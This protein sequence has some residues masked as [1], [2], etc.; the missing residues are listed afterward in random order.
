MKNR[1][2][3]YIMALPIAFIWF[4]CN[5]YLD[6]MPDN[7]MELDSESKIAKLLVSA[8]PANAYIM[9][10]ELSSDNVDNY[11][12]YNPYYTRFTEQIY[13]WEEGKETGTNEA[14]D[15]IWSACY[16]AIASANQA[17]EAIKELGN[18]ESL[19]AARGEALLARAYSHFILVNV[20]CQHYS[21]KYAESDMGLPYMEEPEKELFSVRERG[22]LARDYELMAKDIEEGLPL[23]KDDS[24]EVPKYHFNQKAAYTFASRFYLFTH[25]WDKVIQYASLALGAVPSEL[26]RNYTPLVALPR[27]LVTVGTQ[28]TA[29]ANKCNFLVQTAYSNLGVV[30]GA[31]Y[32]ESRFNHGALLARF[33]THN[34]A[35]WGTAATT[36]ATAFAQMYKLAPYVYSGTNLDKVLC[37]RIPYMFEYTDPVAGVGYRRAVYVALSAEEALLNRA[38]AYVMKEQYDKALSDINLWTVNTLSATQAAPLLTEAGIQTWATGLAY[39]TPQ[40]PTPK[41]RLNPDFTTIADGSKQESFIHCILLMRRHEFIHEGMR[42]FDVKRWGIEIYRRTV[43]ADGISVKSV[44]D[45]L[46]VRDNRRA[47]QVPQSVISA[48]VTPNPR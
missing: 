31:Y 45:E 10:T 7:R 47:L 36:N 5:D 20:F 6:V 15:D 43:N 3:Y 11:G 44:D 9:N 38:E 46:K 48:G 33:E 14:V 26:L 24:Y 19:D 42:W 30:F 28:Y 8:Y 2:L 13:K 21:E 1:Y 32:T 16:S 17:L 25:N 41:K 39:Y 35:P 22:T 29:T 12:D 4:S 40:A 23:I 37:P 34:F 18:P 27:N